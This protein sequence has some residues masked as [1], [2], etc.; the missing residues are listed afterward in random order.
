MKIF[1]LLIIATLSTAFGSNVDSLYVRGNEH[2]IEGDFNDDQRQLVKVGQ[3]RGKTEK[4]KRER[5]RE[6]ERKI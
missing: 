5:E 6:R 4:R 1:I 3:D 2:Y